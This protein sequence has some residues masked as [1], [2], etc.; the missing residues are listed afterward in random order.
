[1]NILVDRHHAGLLYALQLLFEDRLGLTLYTPVG[2]EWWDAGYWRFGQSYGD[3]RL[4]AQYLNLADATLILREGEAMATRTA[5]PH[6]SGLYYTLYDRNEYPDREIRGVTLEQFREMGD[7][8]YVV[9]TVQDNQYGFNRLAHEVGAKYVYQI[10]NHHQQ[11]DWSLNP[12]VLNSSETV[13]QGRGVTIHQ[14][15]EKDTVFKYRPPAYDK[16]FGIASAATFINCFPGHPNQV[17]YYE[18][19]QALLPEWQW[20]MHGSDGA[21]GK[22]GPYTRLAEVMAMY[23]FGW[24]D[25]PHGDGF[26]HVIHYL[27]S[28]GRPLIGHASYYDGLF[29][30]PLWEDGIT[31]IN[32]DGRSPAEVSQLLSEVAADPERHEQMCRTIRQRVDDI[33]D[34]DAE[35]AQVRSLLGL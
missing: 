28:V 6:E 30:G 3:D 12:L 7:F 35:E 14:E 5:I 24:H 11:C 9:A 19:T 27:A 33:V 21:H 16:P 34:F 8:G 20:G 26:G 1:M 10:G 2:H 22:V 23:G 4:A 31:S 18:T 29:A 13:L 15:Y 25:K 32:L 17:T